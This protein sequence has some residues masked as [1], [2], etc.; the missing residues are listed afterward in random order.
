[1]EYYEDHLEPKRPLLV[2]RMQF[3]NLIRDESESVEKYFMALKTLDAHFEIGENNDER[4]RDQFIIK[5]VK[6]CESTKTQ[7]AEVV[8]LASLL[9]TT[10]FTPENPKVFKTF[11]SKR[12]ET[13]CMNC[14]N[15]YHRNKGD[16]PAKNF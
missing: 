4:I 8:K 15:P 9:E 12:R 1:M 14:G 3:Q 5:L 16:C 10:Y 11:M 7:L 6:L 2:R 13:D